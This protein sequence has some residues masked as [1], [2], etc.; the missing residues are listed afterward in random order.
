[1]NGTSKSDFIVSG[2]GTDIIDGRSG[3]DILFAGWLEE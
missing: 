1:M 2:S 3:S